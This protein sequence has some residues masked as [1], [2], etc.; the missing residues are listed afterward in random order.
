[1]IFLSRVDFR[2]MIIIHNKFFGTYMLGK[3]CH[4]ELD[5]PLCISWIKNSLSWIWSEVISLLVLLEDSL[6]HDTDAYSTIV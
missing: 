2:L 3:I 6:R 4:N 5:T 1:M